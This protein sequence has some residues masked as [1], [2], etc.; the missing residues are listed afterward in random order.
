MFLIINTTSEKA[1][2]ILTKG[3]KIF[4]YYTWSSFGNLSETLLIN[5][6]KILKK[7]K[8]KLPDIKGVG[9]VLG[10]GSYT[11]LRIGLTTANTLGVSLGIP[12]VGIK[13]VS[14]K[15][16]AKEK[17]VEI[18][19]KKLQK[20]EFSEILKPIYRYPLKITRPKVKRVI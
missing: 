13:A 2:V 9:A 20:K 4:D 18:F 7:N 16:L 3:D 14:R 12:L 11:G 15:Q 19:Y 8:V 17:L 1:E 6:D 10:P 5:I